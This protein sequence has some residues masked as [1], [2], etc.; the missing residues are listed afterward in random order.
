MHKKLSG[1]KLE[2]FSEKLGL[3]FGLSNKKLYPDSLILTLEF[4]NFDFS[5]S[6]VMDLI[7]VATAKC[8]FNE[9]ESNYL[10][11]IL[12]KHTALQIFKNSVSQKRN[13]QGIIDDLTLIIFNLPSPKVLS[14]EGL[15][16]LS[17]SRTKVD[18]IAKSFENN[19]KYSLEYLL[20]SC[21]IHF[22][23]NKHIMEEF[24][25]VPAVKLEYLVLLLNNFDDWIKKPIEKQYYESEYLHLMIQSKIFQHAIKGK[26][27][28]H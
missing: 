27:D 14:D 10:T 25:V 24:K 7:A 6:G 20:N 19:S 9:E 11:A 15:H 23:F 2:D 21:L 28:F 5:V 22:I 12:G 18:V 8:S 3:L 1:K 16:L 13:I 4:N 17:V 26:N